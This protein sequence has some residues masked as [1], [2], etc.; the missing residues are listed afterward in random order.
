VE[1]VQDFPKERFRDGIDDHRSGPR[2]NGSNNRARQG[3]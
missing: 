3:K 1:I 2:Q